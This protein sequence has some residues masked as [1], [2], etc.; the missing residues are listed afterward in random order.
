MEQREIYY[1][2]KRALCYLVYSIFAFNL[3][4]LI[5]DIL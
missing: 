2:E 1:I 5:T 4:V 3:T